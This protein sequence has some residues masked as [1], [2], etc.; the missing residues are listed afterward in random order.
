MSERLYVRPPEGLDLNDDAALEAWVT[1]VWEA[2]VERSI[3]PA[4]AA[5]QRDDTGDQADRAADE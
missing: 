2:F 5:D 4:P 3:T 1:S